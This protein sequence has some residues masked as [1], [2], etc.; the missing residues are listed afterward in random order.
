M[1]DEVVGDNDLVWGPNGFA[2][3]LQPIGSQP[4]KK[5]GST[6]TT[7]QY[8]WQA[9]V[10]GG[11]GKKMINPPHPKT[12]QPGCCCCCWVASIV[13]DSVRPHRRQPT[14]L[15]RPWD[16][17]GKSTGGGCHCLLLNQITQFYMWRWV[18]EGQ[19]ARWVTQ[20]ELPPH[21]NLKPEERRFPMTLS[22]FS[23]WEF[24][25]SQVLIRLGT[26]SFGK[27]AR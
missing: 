2:C 27:D 20:M 22:P 14:R 4:E 16:F 7:L 19:K 26:L 24:S 11:K 17:P 18:R 10:H 5:I 15:P 8:H 25:N 6:K 13:S 1:N 21:G 12:F 9:L 3:S 23:H